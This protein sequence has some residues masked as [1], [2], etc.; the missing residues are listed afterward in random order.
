MTGLPDLFPGFEGHTVDTEGATIFAR[1]GGSGQ[2]LLLLHGFPQSHVMWHKI[3]PALAERFTLVI[4]DLRGYGASSCPPTDATGFPYSKRAM[5]NDMVQLMEAF[6]FGEFRVCG[7][8]RGARV[9]YRMAL[10]YGDK[11]LKLAVLDIVP[12]FAMWH[13][14]D[15]HMAMKVYHWMFLAQPYPLPETLI[16]RASEYYLDHT[17]ASWTK[18]KDLSAFDKTALAHYR[19]N[20]AR[21]ERIR[22]MC[23][24]YR[25]GASYD[26]RADEADH[27]AGKK[28]GCPTLAIWGDAGIPD[29][30]PLETWQKWA[31]DVVGHPVDSGHFICEENPQAALDALLPFMRK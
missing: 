29:A 3:A 20:M 11:V 14:M 2:P 28:I 30:P 21:P 22:A 4:P 25:S 17:I 8:D 13:G 12:T 16:E 27:E 5:A 1:C 24:D 31:N 19:A 6:G 26:L 15:H 9:A 18:D 7:H 10:D 23:E